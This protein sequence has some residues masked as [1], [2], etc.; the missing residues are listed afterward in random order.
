MRF[1]K[2][3]LKSS[4]ILAIWALLIITLIIGYYYND[5]PT[6]QELEAKNK[7]QIVTIYYSNQEKITTL[8]D[9]YQDDINFYELPKHLINAV[10]ATED[11]RFF[12]HHGVDILGIIR[13]SIANY[14]SKKLVQGGSTITQQLTKLLFLSSEKTFKR[15]IQEVLLAI[16]LERAFS[17]EQI[18][19]LYLNRAYFGSGNY[20]VNNAAKF[21]FHKSVSNLTLNEA[22]IVAGVLKAPSK[23][24]PINNPKLALIRAKEVINNMVEA[25]FLS[26][27]K[28]NQLEPRLDYQNSS[29]NNNNA[30]LAK[31]Y[32]V[33]YIR[34]QF[35][36]YLSLKQ[37]KATNLEIITTLNEKIQS[38]LENILNKFIYRHFKKLANSELAVVIMSKDGAIIAMSGGKDYRKSQYNRAL[39]AKRQA[40]SAFKTLVY[41]TAFE[42]GFTPQDLFEDKKINI[43]NWNPQNYN[44]EYQG[45]ITLKSAFASSSNS[46]AIQLAAKINREQLIRNAK[47][48]G[49]IST[50]DKNDSTIALGTTEVTPLELTCV[51]AAIANGGYPIIPYAI[52]TIKNHE[53]KIIYQRDSSGLEK[54]ISNTTNLYLRE[55]LREVVEN[56]TG[57]NANIAANIYG[58]TGTSQ[59]FRDAWF[60]GFN[61]EYVIGI[62]IG[63]DN[64][65]PTNK[66]T[67]GGLPALLFAEIIREIE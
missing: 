39:Y 14:K 2:F 56:G 28:K 65:S 66:I 49:I 47:K 38:K 4:I 48:L 31:L 44:H 9:I 24:S 34:D 61:D 16:Q 3:I 29:A 52:K 42:N 33:D 57:K 22:A 21:Y 20:G 60:I 51:Y 12:S 1:L 10:I 43:G 26:L 35:L 25:G 23:L 40:G 36:E 15:K 11:R 67:G 50:I 63:N 30:T 53:N 13:A 55:I 5:L 6:L 18:L 58:K 45:E 7:K 19:T 37:S 46:V 32:F 59:D 64:N 8:G 27:N 41:L 17:K 54:I 62:W